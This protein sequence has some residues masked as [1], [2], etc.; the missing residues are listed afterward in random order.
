M[1]HR[2]PGEFSKS[3]APAEQYKI[4]S[5]PGRASTISLFFFAADFPAVVHQAAMQ[6]GSLPKSIC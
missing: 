4:R 5:F 1:Y 6:Q 3:V 2:F